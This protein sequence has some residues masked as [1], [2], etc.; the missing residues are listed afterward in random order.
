M[1]HSLQAPELPVIC[2][3]MLVHEPHSR[4]PQEFKY[5]QVLA[6]DILYLIWEIAER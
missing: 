2:L 1:F 6:G 5:Y 3:K 4:D